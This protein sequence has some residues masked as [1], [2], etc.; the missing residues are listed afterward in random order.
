MVICDPRSAG[1][2]PQN[3]GLRKAEVEPSRP[4]FSLLALE[5]ATVYPNVNNIDGEMPRHG[6]ESIFAGSSFER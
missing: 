6:D 2:L 4:F 1:P 5:A 3:R